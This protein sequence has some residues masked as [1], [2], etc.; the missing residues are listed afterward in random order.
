MN[1]RMKKKAE[2]IRRKKLHRILDQ[3]IDINGLGK[4]QA[5]LTGDKPTAFYWFNGHTGDLSVTVHSMGWHTG[6]NPSYRA[7]PYL[8]ESQY[9]PSFDSVIRDLDDLKEQLH[10]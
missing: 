2:S 5:K 1:R 10:V 8:D 4:R 3:V 7:D 6:S 9:G